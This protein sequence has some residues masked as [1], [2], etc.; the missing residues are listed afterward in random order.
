MASPQRAEQGVAPSLLWSSR[1]AKEHSLS[2]EWGSVY[3]SHIDDY[4]TGP[5]FIRRTHSAMGNARG[6][7]SAPSLTLKRFEIFGAEDALTNMPLRDPTKARRARLDDL[8]SRMKYR[9]SHVEALTRRIESCESRKASREGLAQRSGKFFDLVETTTTPSRPS[10]AGALR[11]RDVYRAPV[12][13]SH[14]VGWRAPLDHPTIGRTRTPLT[15]YNYHCPARP[16]SASH[17]SYPHQIHRSPVM[18]F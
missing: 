6:P 9:K 11:P 18:L 17:V 14:E 5:A 10:T 4:L 16:H 13:T 8:K 12:L 1:V 15:S 7:P 3:L 2:K